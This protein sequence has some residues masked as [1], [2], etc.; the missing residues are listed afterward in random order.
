MIPDGWKISRVATVFGAIH[1]VGPDGLH[2]AYYDDEPAVIY[3][4][5]DALL[6]QTESTSEAAK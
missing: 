1:V 6:K 3:Q 2:C 5:L 4:F